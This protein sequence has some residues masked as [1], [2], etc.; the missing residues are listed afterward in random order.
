VLEPSEDSGE[1]ESL[2]NLPYPE[3]GVTDFPINVP[4]SPFIS[5]GFLSRTASPYSDSLGGQAEEFSL[6]AGWL[7]GEMIWGIREL[8]EEPMQ[9]DWRHEVVEELDRDLDSWSEVDESTRRELDRFR[10]QRQ[11][12]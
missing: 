10:P 4:A 2:P 11:P 3:L 1:L 7:D 12:C 5:D 9:W 8:E 6:D